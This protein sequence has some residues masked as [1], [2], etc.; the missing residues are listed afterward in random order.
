M[1]SA[2]HPNAKQSVP[3]SPFQS[4]AQTQSQIQDSA[5]RRT[6]SPP[7][8]PTPAA[9]PALHQ[10]KSQPTDAPRTPV[11][12]HPGGTCPGD[13]RCDGTGG[14]SACN[15]CPTYNN[16]LQAGV[17]DPAN[18]APAQKADAT[19][20]V[21]EQ[22]A[23][24]SGAESSPVISAQTPANSRSRVRSQVGALSCANCGTSTTPLWRRDDVGNNICN[25]CGTCSPQ[26]SSFLPRSVARKIGAGR[27]S[28][29]CPPPPWVIVHLPGVYTAPVR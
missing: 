7:T 11:Q 20:P 25:A 4:S 22:G 26:S 18:G 17:V 21:V 13:G 28:I 29:L 16:A 5:A 23:E 2:T 1:Q 14:T 8:M 3:P 24:T 19:A 27:L 9:S 12:K 6:A 10:T 15:G